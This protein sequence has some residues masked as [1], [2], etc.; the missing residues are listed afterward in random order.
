MISL[1]GTGE[2]EPA[3]KWHESSLD[4]MLANT[5]TPRLKGRRN[6]RETAGGR[7]LWSCQTGPWWK[8][9]RN[10]ANHFTETLMRVTDRGLRTSTAQLLVIAP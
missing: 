7:D 8:L 4:N 10:H 2:H 6:L 3:H 1:A 9:R 5:E